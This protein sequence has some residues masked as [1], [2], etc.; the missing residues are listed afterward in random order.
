MRLKSEQTLAEIDARMAELRERKELAQG[1]LR[2]LARMR[3]E[4]IA[5]SSAGGSDE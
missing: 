2:K 4:V 1:E 5:Q 3:D